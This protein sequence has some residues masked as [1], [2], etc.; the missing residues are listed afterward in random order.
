MPF[1]SSIMFALLALPAACQAQLNVAIEPLGQIR[2]VR[3]GDVVYLTDLAVAINKPGWTGI[4]VDQRRPD[5]GSVQVERNGARTTYS[6][7]MSGEGAPIRLRET[8]EV[9]PDRVTVRYELTA[10]KDV[11]VECV[12]VQ[13]L[14]PTAVHAG[15]TRYVE[16]DG[17]GTQGLCPAELNAG[18][19]LIVGGRAAD[20]IGFGHPG[21]T[22][23]RVIPEAMDLQFQDNRK[24]DTP[25]FGLLATTGS[26]KLAAGKTVRF[27]LTFAADTLAKLDTEARV[28]ALNDP[29]TLKLGDNR[30][31]RLGA[32]KL[33]HGSV[34][35]YDRL[36][37]T[38][39]LAATYGNPFDADEIAVDALIT[40]PGGRTV[41]V[42]CFYYVPMKLTTRS[43]GERLGVDGTPGFRLRYTPLAPGRYRL[44]VRAADRSGTAKSS[45]ITFTATAKHGS[46][47]IR[48]AKA[49]PRYFAYDDGKPY[50]AV[51]ENV[52]W[53]GWRS[54]IADY[55]KWL[56][57]L[58][59]A[60]GNWARL[61]LAFN[62]KGLEWMPAPTPKAGIGSYLGLGRY[63][64]DNAWRLDRVVDLARQ[65]GVRVM[66][67]L[68]TYGEF[69]EGGFFGEG[70]WISNPYNA[71]NGGPCATSADFWTNERAR[72]L[73]KQRLRYLIARWGYSPDLF[74]WEFW[75]EV[76]ATPEGNV[77]IA[78]MAAYLKQH[79]PNRHLV[80]TTYGDA[81]TWRCADIDFSMKH[82]Y[83]QAGN[84]ADFTSRIADE[85]R[86]GLSHGKP[87]LLAE[88]GI[89]WQT[90][91][92]K[93]DPKG[94]GISMRNGAWA[95]MMVGSA[96]TSM[97]WYWDG[98]V[99]PK[100]LYH[101]L[102]PVGKFAAT[103][104]WAKERFAPVQGI[105]VAA[106]A[107]APET[108]SDVLIPADVEWGITPS[109]E[110]TV[111]RDG[112]VQGGPVAM[113]I[114]S[115]SRANP[116]ELHQKLTW[117]VD[118]PAA[119]KVVLRLGNVCSAAHPVIAV[120]GDVRYDKA[121]AAGEPGK[122]PWK[123]A[124]YL[125]QYKI[126]VADY[127]EEI[128][129]DVPAGKHA[130][131]V[132]NAAG[133]WF[134]IRSVAIAAYR[135]SRYPDV[136]ALGLA[137]DRLVL[138]WVH[139]RQSTW[140]TAYDGKTPGVLSG[141]R[142]SVPVK[143]GGTWRVEWWNTV[144]GEVV[145]RDTVAAKGGVLSLAAP[146]FS[147]DLAVRCARAVGWL[148]RGWYWMGTDAHRT[149]ALVK[150][151]PLRP[152][153]SAATAAAH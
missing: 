59:A 52:C 40:T 23:L 117:N 120:D 56:K 87:Y 97:L 90:D 66:L 106:S 35:A 21:G 30:P 17:M 48:V 143:G 18:N 42:P 15:K 70:S 133:D 31:L 135:S 79:D 32:V 43:G 131:T 115:P 58:G 141:L 127:D 61:W 138:L 118:M 34:A 46:G 103:V 2:E 20:W 107:S 96:G 92:G 109:A 146:D 25:A 57:G 75:N 68:G 82:M 55:T 13:G 77:W 112:T 24:W 37:A 91:D 145:R 124:R 63:A 53:S 152:G 33:D 29:A 14:M 8:A 4:L 102:T 134:Q 16:A 121:L 60:G 116:K 39:E 1:R 98:Y 95:S 3:V 86:E 88:F 84:V 76:P 151:T 65:N 64:Q 47:F 5:P 26:G 73:Y 49:A 6:L 110:Y 129:L 74:A 72:K 50:F 140:R 51:G 139:N 62:E 28:M 153:S 89:D 38:I 149:T 126:W 144:T 105:Q 67:C 119:G 114:G 11:P 45:A 104:N 22:A 36:E 113:T 137:S 19:Y 44:V 147:T 27:A 10:E 93:W 111:R 78:E 7:T 83:G 122:G 142:A 108:F 125:E 136:N 85:A 81:G 12:L 99:H 123:S 130:I 128:A 9:A 101:V 80:S 150:A 148:A 54:P 94:L 100:D 41:T 71:M 132:A 69:T